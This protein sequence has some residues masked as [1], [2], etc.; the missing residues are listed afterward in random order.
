MPWK[1]SWANR[2]GENE[3][4]DDKYKN[5]SERRA[6]VVKTSVAVSDVKR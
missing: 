3:K 1:A 5:R 6:P 4:R 2:T